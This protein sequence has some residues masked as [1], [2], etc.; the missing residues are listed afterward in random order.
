MRALAV[1]EVAVKVVFLL[2]KKLKAQS[3]RKVS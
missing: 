2:P 3:P 1:V